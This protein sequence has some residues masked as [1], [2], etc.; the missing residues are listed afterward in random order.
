MLYTQF[1]DKTGRAIVLNN[2]YQKEELRQ[3]LLEKT[4]LREE[5]IDEILS[6]G[7]VLSDDEM[8]KV[9]VRG[10]G[11]I[12]TE[13]S[14]VINLIWTGQQIVIYPDSSFEKYYSFWDMLIEWF[15]DRVDDLRDFFK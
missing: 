5:R 4:D 14:N 2:T 8:I 13:D 9:K 6:E 1:Q 12:T 15:W 10:E 7:I 3:E 11:T